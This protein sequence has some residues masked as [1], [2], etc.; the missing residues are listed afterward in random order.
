MAQKFIT[1]EVEKRMSKYPLY[2][3]DGAGVNA[4][5]TAKFFYPAGA[6]TWYVLEYDTNDKDTCY[7]IVINGHGEGEYGYFSLKELQGI[8]GRFGLGVER[9]TYFDPIKVGDIHDGGY[10]ENFIKY[11]IG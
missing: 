2:S 6:W 3:Q 4:V 8:R 5:I 1:K 9:D 10:L 11:M 7:G